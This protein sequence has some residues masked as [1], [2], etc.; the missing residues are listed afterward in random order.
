MKRISELQYQ[1]N[2]VSIITFQLTYK[3]F[4]VVGRGKR[5]TTSFRL[6]VTDIGGRV[7]LMLECRTESQFKLF[8]FENGMRVRRRSRW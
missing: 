2:V 3:K 4:R 5:I 1:H 6:H 8:V 7:G